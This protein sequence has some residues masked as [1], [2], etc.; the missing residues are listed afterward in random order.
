MLVA[1]LLIMQHQLCIDAHHAHSDTVRQNGKDTDVQKHQRF[2]RAMVSFCRERTL[3]GCCDGPITVCLQGADVLSRARQCESMQA[4]APR[5]AHFDADGLHNV[6]SQ[7]LSVAKLIRRRRASR[8]GDSDV[9]LGLLETWIPMML[10]RWCCTAGA[11][12]ILKSSKEER[13]HAG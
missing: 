4:C 9:E 5:R 7:L 10:Y 12:P 13:C 1:L 2:D 3:R 8:L 11:V 6:T